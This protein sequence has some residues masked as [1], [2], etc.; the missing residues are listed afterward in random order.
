MKLDIHPAMELGVK[1]ILI[2]RHNH[3]PSANVARI[4]NLEEVNQWL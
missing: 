2:D 4:Q 3:F 1:A